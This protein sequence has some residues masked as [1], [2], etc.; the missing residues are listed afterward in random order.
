MQIPWRAAPRAA[1]SS[2]LTLLVSVATTLLLSFVVAAAVMHASASGS[3]ALAY[4]ENLLCEQ[5][6]HPTVEVR[7]PQLSAT[8]AQLGMAAARRHAGDQPVVAAAYVAETRTDFGGPPTFAKFGYRDGALDHL[9]VVEGGGRD[10]LWVPKSVADTTKITLGARGMGG[11]LPPVTAIYADVYDPLDPWWCSERNYVVPNAIGRVDVAAAVVWAPTMDVFK[12]LPPEVINHGVAMT[13][14]FPTAPPATPGQG[15]A[16]LARGTPVVDAT[17]RELPGSSRSA[18]LAVPI[19]NARET[20]GNVT[21]AILPLTV[22]SIL[23]GLAGV[24]TVAVQ[25]AQRRRDELRLLW[26]RGAGPLALGWRAVLEL[27]A[28]MV[29]GAVAGLGVARLLLPVYAPATDLAEGTTGVAVLCVVAVFALS[30]VVT[31]LVVALRVHRMFQK[32][33]PPVRSPARRI[34]AAT[35]WELATAVLAFLAWGRVRDNGLATPLTIGGLPRVD[36]AALAFP[37]LVVLTTA[38]LAAR[39]LRLVLR[40]SHRTALWSLPATQLAI[41]RLAAAA[42][43]VTG[44]LLVGVLA[45]GTIAVGSSISEAEKTALDVKSGMFTGANS[46][47]QV[48]PALVEGA[49]LP[50]ELR[51]HATIVGLSTEGERHLLVVDPATFTDGAY[52]RGLDPDELRA[53]LGAPFTVGDTTAQQVQFPGMTMVDATAHRGDVP[54]TG[55][56]GDRR[57]PRPGGR[58]ARGQR[59][60][61]VVVAAAGR[62]RRGPATGGRPLQRAPGT[63][64]GVVRVAVPDHPVDVRVRHRAGRGAGRGRRARAAAGHRGAPT[65]ERGVRGAEHPDGDAPGD[66]AGQPPAGAGRAGVAGGGDRVRGQRGERGR[67]DPAP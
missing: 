29:V 7:R 4:Q 63:R 51:G 64:Q 52:T 15:D 59:L 10:G 54:E 36:A 41:R 35:P 14:R 56:R 16:L 58:P 1:L 61:R 42:G 23:I 66:A 27:V 44:V 24:G 2:P 32:P 46:V 37:L 65:A 50:A 40:A 60:V 28:P 5:T 39:L 34:L 55:Q 38:L 21:S 57:H 25:W 9:K 3:A 33:A 45:I 12:D 62:A 13:I 47:V 19:A 26:C 17:A 22:I 6:M 20:T 8:G 53:R 43:P 31:G 11:R 49:G 67:G 48:S 30:V 18:P